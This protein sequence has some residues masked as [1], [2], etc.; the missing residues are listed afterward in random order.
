MNHIFYIGIKD[1][2]EP[3]GGRRSFVSLVNTEIS[4]LF[5]ISSDDEPSELV[6]FSLLFLFSEP[7]KKYLLLVFV[8]SDDKVSNFCFFSLISDDA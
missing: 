3:I 4:L 2:K 8:G 7:D 5:E 6:D 1:G